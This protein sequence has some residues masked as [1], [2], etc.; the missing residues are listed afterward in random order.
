MN[1]SDPKE[2]KSPKACASDQSVPSF[3]HIFECSHCR[4]SFEKV[5][6]CGGVCCFVCL[7][8]MHEMVDLYGLSVKLLAIALKLYVSHI[9]A[10]LYDYL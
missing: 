8:D 3:K 9:Y 7:E 1:N 2:M 10:Q 5:K 6:M 4:G